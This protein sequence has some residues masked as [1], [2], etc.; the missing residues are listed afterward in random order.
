MR[1]TVR[2]AVAIAIAIALAAPIA[3]AD[4]ATY[5]TDFVVLADASVADAARIAHLATKSVLRASEKQCKGNG[6]VTY[7]V[8]G[9]VDGAFTKAGAKERAYIVTTMMCVAPGPPVE[10]GPNSGPG[11][12]MLVSPQSQ[13]VIVRGNAAVA[14]LPVDETSIAV[15]KDLDN[16]GLAEILL[17][18]HDAFG[19]GTTARMVSARDGKLAVVR[20]FGQVVSGCGWGKATRTTITYKLG[21]HGLELA[22]STKPRVCR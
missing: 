3:V 17:A 16:D 11:L 20:D 18:N 22:T 4:D 7:K 2:S 19:D 13:L 1:R 6:D 21:D 8:T 12:A 15:A 5:L 9:G 10:I 14:K